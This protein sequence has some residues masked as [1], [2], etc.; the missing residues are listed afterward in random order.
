LIQV[1]T[2]LRIKDVPARLKERVNNYFDALWD[3]K[4]GMD[5]HEVMM[6]P[7]VVLLS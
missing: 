6:R 2:F 4:R 7:F 1:A 5:E 3:K